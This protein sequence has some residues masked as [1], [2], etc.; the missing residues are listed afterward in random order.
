[1]CEN[2]PPHL[3]YA[4]PSRWHRGRSARR[5]A[6]LCLALIVA[7]LCVRWGGVLIHRVEARY[8]F[9][10]CLSYSAK[11]NEV[12]YDGPHDA[13]WA[14]HAPR[15]WLK[16][17]ADWSG[18]GVPRS[19]GVLFLH[20]RSTPSGERRLVAVDVVSVGAKRYLQVQSRVFAPPVGMAPARLTSTGATTL[21]LPADPG[22]LQIFEG[23]IDPKNA[24]HFELT[25]AIGDRRGL[26]DG[27]LKN[28][29]TV[30]LELRNP[31]IDSIQPASV[32]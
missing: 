19:F 4:P 9:G 15:P 1:M 3:D 7:G 5:I 17:F 2:D 24:S 23:L 12:A 22:E 26:I 25:F 10:R 31:L 28:D 21:P 13:G 16:F 11:P 27:W 8:W 30:I 32:P 14:A 29:N 6:A 20:E 18:S